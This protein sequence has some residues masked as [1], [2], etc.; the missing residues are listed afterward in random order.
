VKPRSELPEAWLERSADA[1]NAHFWAD[2]PESL[3]D[4]ERLYVLAMAEQ[5][6]DTVWHTAAA[7]ARGGVIVGPFMPIAPKFTPMG[8]NSYLRWREEHG[9]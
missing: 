9:Y 5:A 4:L 2:V 7:A 3:N 6:I 8:E 1:L